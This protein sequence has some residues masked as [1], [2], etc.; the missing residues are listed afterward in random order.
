V[1]WKP[2][3]RFQQTGRTLRESIVAASPG[4]LREFSITPVEYK[5][6]RPKKND[7]DRVQ[8]CAQAICLEEMLGV[9][10]A[11]GQLYYGTKRRRF[12][13]AFDVRLRNVTREAAERFHAMMASGV[14]PTAQYEKKCDTCSLFEVC[15]PTSLS[16]RQASR[17]LTSQIA[18]AKSS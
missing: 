9:E 8:L 18:H 5:R 14:T 2:P 3:A 16:S 11:A 6:G 1:L 17:Y 4:E 13:V 15:L 12:N 10:I 7:C